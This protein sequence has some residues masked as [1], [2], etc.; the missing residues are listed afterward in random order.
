MVSRNQKRRLTDEPNIKLNYPKERSDKIKIMHYVAKKFLRYNAPAK[1][2]DST[3]L[4]SIILNKPT[5]FYKINK[6]FSYLIYIII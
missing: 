3:Y 2:S 5:N 1:G 6:I 4:T